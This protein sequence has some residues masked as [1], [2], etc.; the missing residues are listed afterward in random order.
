MQWGRRAGSYLLLLELSRPR[1]IAVGRLGARHFAAGLY[2]YLGSALGAGGVAGRC[3][4]HICSA[5]RPR[6]HVDYLRARTA[7]REIWY[8]QDGVRWEHEWASA[9]IGLPMLRAPVPGFGASDCRCRAHL[10][11]MPTNE[12]RRSIAEALSRVGPELKIRSL[13][14][15]AAPDASA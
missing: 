13:G 3:K 9:C 11:A 1:E 2:F 12:D 14:C 8:T 7:L 10:F 4:H 5:A 6:W 15:S